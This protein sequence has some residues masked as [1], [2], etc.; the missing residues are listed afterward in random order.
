MKHILYVKTHCAKFFTQS[1]LFF[2]ALFLV[3]NVFAQQQQQKPEYKKF[4][5]SYHF[6][7]SGDPT[8]LF[9]LDGKYYNNWGSAYSNDLVH[10]KYSPYG[11]IGLRRQLSDSSLTKSVRDSLTARI[12]R[13]GGTGVVVFD[14]NNTSGLGKGGVPPLIS[15]W[16]NNSQPWGNQIIGLAYSN[17]TVKTWTRYEKFPVL[18]INNREFRDPLVFWYEP[19]K[20]WVMAISLAEAPKIQFYNSDN[21]KD[22]TFMSEFGPWGAV[23]GVWECPDFFPLVVDGD[24]NKIKWV[25]ALSVQPLNGQYFIGDFDGKRFNLDPSFAKQLNYNKYIPQGTLLFDF[26][27]GLDGWEIEGEAFSQ[28]PSNQALNGQG[29]V[30]GHFGRFYLNSHNGKGQATGKLTSPPFTITKQYINF[31]AGG[32][33]N[34][35]NQL[36]NL[37]IDGRKVYSQ[38]GNNSGGLS[39]YSWNVSQYLGKEGRLEA[40]DKG[41]GNILADQFMLSDEPAKGDREK[42]FWVDYGPDFFALRSWGSYAPNEKRRIWSGW[43][44]SWRYASVEP[45][46]GIQ[47]VPRS[48][49]LKTFSEGIRLVQTP[50]Q[51]LESLRKNFKN[52]GEA[53]FEGVWKS[54]KIKVP[55]NTYELIVEIENVS[56]EEFGMKIGVGNNQQTVIGYK[57]KEEEIYVDR[58]K[59]GLVDF[60][61]LFPQLNK[62]S[63]KNRN[64]TL[65]LHLFVDNSSMEVFANGGEACI[66]SKIYPDPTSTGI[67]FFSTKGK[68]KIK[69]IKLWELESIELEK[70]LPDAK[71]LNAIK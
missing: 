50:I 6:Y 34:P 29:A 22:W 23:G 40:E 58:Q 5:P 48:V 10:W 67:E 44:G 13:L 15:L 28:A 16:H 7:P 4:N 69:T 31:L 39:W 26:E 37:I 32:N 17:D 57:I 12:P 8:G 20:K 62:G 47:S 9:F 46:R 61:G 25:L 51:E 18:D 53:I 55:K 43:M 1:S 38:T 2:I 42:A 33:Y 52:A 71:T 65:T 35:E 21:L 27:R 60:S 64:N 70:T 24:S 30:M 56:A 66:S 49:T 41:N 63:L 19:T 11:A 68:V 3:L 59:S 14:R 54:D 45:V 36:I